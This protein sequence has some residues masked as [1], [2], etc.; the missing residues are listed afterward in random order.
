VYARTTTIEATPSSIDAGVSY[1]R[2]AVMPLLAGMD[3]HIG[4]ALL[5]D[6]SSSRC[7]TTSAWESH[8]A[9]RA[10]AAAVDDVRNRAAELSAA[11][12]PPSRSGRS[13]HSTVTRSTRGSVRSRGLGTRRHRSDRFGDR[14]VQTAMSAMAEIEGFCS[15]SLLVNRTSGRGVSSMA[16]ASAEAMERNHADMDRLRAS[17]SEEAAAQLL[18]ER[19]FELMIAALRVPEL[20]RV[21]AS[22]RRRRRTRAPAPR[23][24]RSA[25]RRPPACEWRRAPSPAALG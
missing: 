21:R 24:D 17:V 2:D 20:G 18:D 5:A 12:R 22:S 23:R 6:R 7:I 11:A 3:G 4:L 9:M 19:D 14:G 10:S 1:V 15:A 25:P 16:F 8:D 13:R